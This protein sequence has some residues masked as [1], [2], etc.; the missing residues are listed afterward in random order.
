MP[1]LA[2]MLGL[3]TP[4]IKSTMFG[5]L[6]STRFITSTMVT[7]NNCLFLKQKNKTKNKK[8]MQHAEKYHTTDCCKLH[9]FKLYYKEKK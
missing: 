6:L 1:S 9:Y 4:E 7:Y 8:K 5:F 2:R 3:P